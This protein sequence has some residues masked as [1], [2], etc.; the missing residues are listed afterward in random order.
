MS[1]FIKSPTNYIGGKYKLLPQITPYFPKEIDTFVDLFSGGA[2]VGINVNA[3]LIIFNDINK[4]INDLFTWL[5][6]KDPKAV[7][8]QIKSV[9]EKYSLS[10]TNKTGFLRL[11]KDYN[12]KPTSL[13]LY[14]L[15]S[16]SF[17]YQFR[18]N[19][20]GKF[21]GSFGK[22]R[23]RFT[24]NMKNNLIKFINRL[25]NIK[26]VFTTKSFNKLKPEK[27]TSKSFVYVDP[28][29]LLADAAYNKNWS[30]I[31][32]LELYGLLNGLNK[33]HVKF[34]LSNV[35]V[36][37]GHVHRLLRDWA[38]KHEYFV[39]TMNYSY[40]NSSYH[41]RRLPSKEVLVT[42]YAKSQKDVNLSQEDKDLATAQRETVRT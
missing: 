22:N 36:H 18:F 24:K 26:A 39:Y 21:N 11:R 30:S 41:R 19:N 31:N 28:P 20:D 8:D 5:Q 25:N 2:N 38:T 4:K 16:Y 33:H 12:N 10:E 32:E 13:K 37:Q 14:T 17:N 1:N 9:I 35:L 15:V 3:N 7:I 40:T 6:G 23:S 29:Y 27:L 34:A 42:N